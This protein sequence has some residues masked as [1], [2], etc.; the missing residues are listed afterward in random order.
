M[1]RITVGSDLHNYS[2]EHVRTLGRGAFGEVILAR[3]VETGLVVAIK[4][5]HIKNGNKGGLPDNIFREIKS[6]LVL[7]HPNIVRMFDAFPKGH[8][9]ML[10]QEYCCSDLS[11]LIGAARQRFPEGAV[12]G[13]MQQ[14]LRGVWA[15]HGAGIMHRDMKP[16]NILVT[17]SGWIK[18]ADFGLARPLDQGERPLYT[19]TVATRWYRAPEL[20]YGA[21]SYTPAVDIWAVGLVFAELIGLCPLIPGEND[22]DQLGKMIQLLGDIESQWPDVASLPDWG[23]VVFPK[24]TGHPLSELL[25]GVTPSSLGLMERLLRYNPDERISADQALQ[26]PYFFTEPLPLSPS[27]L[28]HVLQID[29]RNN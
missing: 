9:V 12:K 7:D 26:D 2:Y 27:Q 18:L 16:S 1:V 24:S 19:H 20:L 14:L 11:Q 23:K 4:R 13:I 21:R 10:V 15:C 5:I 25:P 29:N 3:V 17:H 8:S 28:C 22:I 6:L